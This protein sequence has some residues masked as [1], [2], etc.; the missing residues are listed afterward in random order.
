MQSSMDLYKSPEGYL[1]NLQTSSPSDARRM[2]RQS[3]KD[4]WNNI[5]AYCG[6]DENLT[7]DHVVPQCKGGLDLLENVVCCCKSCNNDKSHSDW[8]MWYSNQEFFTKERYNA[9]IEWTGSKTNTSLYRYK[10]RRNNAS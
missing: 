10:P 3:I 9:I 4:K 8:Q 7:I 2:W 1:Y 5:C 6:S